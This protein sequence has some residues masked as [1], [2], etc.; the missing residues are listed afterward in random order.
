MLFR[1][2]IYLSEKDL[3]ILKSLR[4]EQGLKSDS[5]VVSYLLKRSTQDKQEVAEAVRKELEKNYLPKERIR[6]G[7]Q[8]AEQNSTVLLDAINTLLHML[9]AKDCISVD[10]APHPVITQ[11]WIAVKRQIAKAK[12]RK[13]ERKSKLG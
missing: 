2:C 10:V 4:E 8:T 1:S 9:N 12:Q 7:V 5:Q 6:F 11:S 3:Q 13:D